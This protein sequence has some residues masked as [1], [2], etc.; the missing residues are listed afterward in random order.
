MLASFGNSLV[1]WQENSKVG[2]LGPV[3]LCGFGARLVP[4]SD[5]E[6]P[7]EKGFKD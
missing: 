7:R 6:Q 5:M 2:I 3:T 4:P 1:Q